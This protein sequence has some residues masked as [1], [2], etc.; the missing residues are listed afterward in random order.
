MGT[1]RVNFGYNTE[2]EW[3]NVGRLDRRTSDEQEVRTG[4][5][6]KVIN[7]CTRFAGQ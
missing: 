6:I 5:L 4:G 2:D 3:R 1:N 7:W